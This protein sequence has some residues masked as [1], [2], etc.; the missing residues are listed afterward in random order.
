MRK[1][2]T[3][4]SLVFACACA[5]PDISQE[6]E[7][8][9]GELGGAEELVCQCPLVLGFDN[10]AECGAAFGIVGSERQ[11]CMREAIQDQEDPKS[12]LSCATNA[13]QLYSVCLTTSIDDGC[14]QS[15]HL[16]CIDEFENAV[17][18][19]SGVSASA[20]GEFLTC[21]NT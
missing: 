16:T 18:Q 19:C 1:T 5:E 2:L 20:A 8:Y 17:L 14:E 12:F 13:V 3:L 7:D 10:A 6:V 4:L 15:Q 9:A 21:E 11:E